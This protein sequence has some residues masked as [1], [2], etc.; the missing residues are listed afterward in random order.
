MAFLKK[1]ERKGL[2]LPGLIDIIFLLLVFSLVTLGFSI[3]KVDTVEDRAEMSGKD[4]DYNLP[5]M[6]AQG[7]LEKENILQTLLILVEHENPEDFDSRKVV[8]TLWP[9]LQDSLTVRE[10][11]DR[12][13]SD[14]L[15]AFFPP[16][17]LTLDDDAFAKSPPCSLI[18]WAIQE[19]KDDHFLVPQNTNSIEMRAVKDTE[20]RIVNFIMEQCSAYGDTI[21]RIL[22]HTLSSKE[23]ESVF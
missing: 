10:A 6:G 15:F 5:E 19:Y 2:S 21:P 13:V 23:V 20:F 1:E 11:K 16:D 17:F 7:T 4:V 3:S 18:R 14:S 22:L 9:S 8:Y 12:A